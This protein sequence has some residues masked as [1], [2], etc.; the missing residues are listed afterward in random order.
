MDSDV[1][2]EEIRNT[3]S[4][5]V[6]GQ[7][8]GSSSGLGSLLDVLLS[9]PELLGRVAGMLSGLSGNTGTGSGSAG[10]SNNTAA[11]GNDDE[12]PGGNSPDGNDAGGG[13]GDRTDDLDAGRGSASPSGGDGTSG[14]DT[15]GFPGGLASLLANRELMEKLPDMMA[16][17]KGVIPAGAFGKPGGPPPPGK[18]PHHHHGKKG[19]KKIALLLALKPYVSP[20]RREAIDYFIRINKF[21]DMFRG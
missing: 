11:G 12:D 21:G 15:F 14:G 17:L 6:T 7:G 2:F 19:D 1:N 4:E 10:G 16:A 8:T 20:A 18:P 13:A 9:N 5:T 3:D